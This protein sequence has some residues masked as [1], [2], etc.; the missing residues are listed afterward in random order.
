MYPVVFSNDLRDDTLANVPDISGSALPTKIDALLML[1]ES[2]DS[3][4]KSIVFSSW[5]S[6]LDLVEI[7]LKKASITWVRFDGRLSQKERQVSL[8]RFQNDPDIRVMLLTLSCGA[9]GLNLTAASRAYLMEPHWN[10][11]L[12]EQALARIHRLGQ[13]KKVTTVR[14]YM[15]NSFEE[16]VMTVQGAKKDLADLLFSPS[17]GPQGDV[18]SGRLQYFRALL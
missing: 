2:L 17:Q 14:F 11:I 18:N 10:P 8:H 16:H 9:V 6:T 3:S 4:T 7:G 15:K 12:E 13:T 1:L 5:T